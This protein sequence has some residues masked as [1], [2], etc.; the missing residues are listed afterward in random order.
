MNIAK[1]FKALAIIGPLALP[2][3]SNEN[4]DFIIAINVNNSSKPKKQ[5][6]VTK[7][8]FATEIIYLNEMQK[9]RR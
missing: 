6:V 3:T 9:K 7:L 2:L 4:S 5:N 8:G 1:D